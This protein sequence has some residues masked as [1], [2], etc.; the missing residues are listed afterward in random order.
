[1]NA[2][3]ICDLLVVGAGPAGSAAARA[4]ARQGVSVLLAERRRRVGLPVRCAE[5]A[6]LP[7]GKYIDWSGPEITVQ[8]VKAMR[9]FLPGAD[10][11]ENLFPGAMI[12]RDRFDQELA[13]QAVTAGARLETGLQIYWRTPEGIWA[14]DG[15]REVLIRPRVIIGADGPCSQ[16]ARWMGQ[17]PGPFLIAAQVS[18]KLAGP[19]DHTRVYF[20]PEISGGYGWVFP[21]GD[22]A[23][24]GVGLE[25]GRSGALKAILEG[26]K[27]Q[28]L[29]EGLVQAPARPAGGGLV[30]VGGL[31]DLWQEN[32]ILAGDAAGTCHPI[33]GAGVG[34]ALISGELAGDAAAAAVIQGTREPLKNYRDELGSL[35]GPSLSRAAAKRRE[36]IRAWNGADFNGLIRKNWIAFR[37]YY[38][39]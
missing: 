37:E 7:V 4:A 14:R 3:L 2:P 36:M 13:R 11:L 19:L 33:S 32:L 29:E 21:K 35:L 9:T 38:R 5:F 34:N 22:R 20:H 39:R 23:N 6:P 27:R 16:V 10:P 28:R 1:M 26:F 12:R 8:T 30:P 15:N 31:K 17:K 25:A 18:L 24:V